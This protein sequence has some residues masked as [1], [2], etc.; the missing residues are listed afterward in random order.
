MELLIID[1]RDSFTYNLVETFR[2]IGIEKIHVLDA[3]SAA[4]DQVLKAEHVLFSPGPGLPEDFPLMHQV[5]GQYK[6]QSR[7]LGVCLGHQAIATF[8][9]AKLEQM[10]S[11]VHGA[12]TPVH[13]S[14]PVTGLFAGLEPVF[15]GGLYHSWMVSEKTLPESLEVTARNDK[16]W[17]MGLKHKELP[18]EGVQFHPE[19]VLTPGGQYILQNWIKMSYHE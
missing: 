1:N 2:R 10:R 19:S 14:Q 3:R 4:P 8:F 6:G 9:G 17:V 18:I 7:I 16:G 12:P 5:L 13:P 15:T 11:V